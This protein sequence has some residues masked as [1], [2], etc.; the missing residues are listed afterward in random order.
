MGNLPNLIIS[1]QD[2]QVAGHYLSVMGASDAWNQAS[3]SNDCLPFP[4]IQI[5]WSIGGPI[6]TLALPWGTVSPGEGGGEEVDGGCHLEGLLETSPQLNSPGTT[7]DQ[8]ISWP[9]LPPRP[10]PYRTTNKL[11]LCH[12]SNFLLVL[13][14]LLKLLKPLIFSA[15]PA[16][17]DFLIFIRWCTVVSKYQTVH[18]VWFVEKISD[19]H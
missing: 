16:V 6:M 17:Y 5:C 11:K 7:P 12:I 18:T 14:Y 1:S 10:G 3:E 8:Q 2:G 19:V 13:L 4:L 15:Q 9:S